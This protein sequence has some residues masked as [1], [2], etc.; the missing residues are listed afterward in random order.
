MRS[1]RLPRPPSRRLRIAILLT[2]AALAAVG[3]VAS[4][5]GSELLIK[6]KVICLECIGIG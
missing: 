2:A 3:A 5:L 1:W 4:G 6:A